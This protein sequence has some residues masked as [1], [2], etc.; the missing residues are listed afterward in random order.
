MR[1]A[2]F[3]ILISA[4]A[5]AQPPNAN[6]HARRGVALYNLGKFDEA[7]VA[8]EDAYTL[9][10][11]DALLF[12]LAQAHRQL[13]HCELA[14]GYYK[15]FMAG[16]PSPALAA[17]VEV[18]LPKLEAA[19]KTKFERPAGPVAT[20]EVAA[21]PP[22]QVTVAATTTPE[23]DE[24]PTIEETAL[25][26]FRVTA[27]VTGGSVISNKSAPI[28][29]VK[30]GLA[31]PIPWLPAS[32]IGVT[33]AT[34]TLFRAEGDRGAAISSLAVSARFN[35]D[36]TW[37]RL[38]IGGDVGATYISS[39]DTSSGVIPGT[40]RAGLWA[41]LLRAEAGAERA[42]KGAF[43]V[44]VALAAAITPRSG[45]MLESMTQIDLCVGLR[46]ER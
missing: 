20:P 35:T 42:I 18:L 12:N 22:P 21:A 45:P 32:E 10:Q 44:R 16:E 31:T 8:F 37:A 41:P 7:I 15:R 28:A 4:T 34:A 33:V 25:P 24:P 1:A 23:I 29:G 30:A 38:T 2:L 9:F 43:A 26:R 3:V 40:R 11:S 46:Y 13:G 36:Q 5:Y 39:L 27:A 19:C 17:Q 14:L 6:A